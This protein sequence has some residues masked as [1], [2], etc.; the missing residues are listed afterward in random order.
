MLKYLTKFALDVLPSVVATILGA[1]IVNH[2]INTKSDTDAPAAAMVAPAN[3]NAKKGGG[4]PVETAKIPEPGIKAKG[5]SERAMIEKSV[6]EGL[7]VV[8]AK[9]TEAKPTEAK[10]AEVKPTEVKPT[11]VKPTEVK[12]TD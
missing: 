2:Y 3:P 11:E 8:E 10:P 9:P 4:K 7:A 1:Y 5:I 6:S 12:P